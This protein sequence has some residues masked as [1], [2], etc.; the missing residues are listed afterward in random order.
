MSKL[1]SLNGSFLCPHK[2][3]TARAA[4][5]FACVAKDRAKRRGGSGVLCNVADGCS[6]FF[7]LD[8]VVAMS[9]A[10]RNSNLL[11]AKKKPQWG[12]ARKHAHNVQL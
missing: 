11:V 3:G 6:N 1:G 8:G 10:H 2:A 5:I 12:Y 4:P 7:S 9:H